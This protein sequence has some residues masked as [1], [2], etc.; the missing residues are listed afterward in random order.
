MA[1]DLSTRS[2]SPAELYNFLFGQS[3]P[4]GRISAFGSVERD[5]R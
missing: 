2:G 5:S 1:A 3:F 4:E